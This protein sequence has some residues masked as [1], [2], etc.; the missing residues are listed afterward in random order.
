MKLNNSYYYFFYTSD[1]YE[2]Y[3]S[4]DYMFNNCSSLTSIN[5]D[6]KEKNDSNNMNIISS[7]FMFNNCL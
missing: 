2:Y 4:M 3:N 1:F 5:F 7:K 6:F